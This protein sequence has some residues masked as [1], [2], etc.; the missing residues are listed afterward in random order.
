MAPKPLSSSSALSSSSS[1]S[2]S[3]GMRQHLLPSGC[4]KLPTEL[5]AKIFLTALF[6]LD[7]PLPQIASTE[8]LKQAPTVFT[9]VCRRW[10]AVALSTPRLW[11]RISVTLLGHARPPKM[12]H[13]RLTKTKM[14]KQKQKDAEKVLMPE[15]VQFAMFQTWLAR[16]KAAP[17]SCSVHN[18][19]GSREICMRYLEALCTHSSH[20]CAINIVGFPLDLFPPLQPDNMQLLEELTINSYS[21]SA[22]DIALTR[23]FARAPR[24]RRVFVRSADTATWRFPWAQLRELYL[25]D[26]DTKDGGPQFDASG[27]HRI[28]SSCSSNLTSL[29]LAFSCPTESPT[30]PLPL[31]VLAPIHLP[32]VLELTLNVNEFLPCDPLLR[33]L[34]L[35]SLRTLKLYT[36]VYP[37]AR[38]LATLRALF[39]PFADTL[40]A[41]DISECKLRAGDALALLRLVPALTA[42]NTCWSSCITPE[43]VR[44]LTLHWDTRGRLEGGQNAMLREL[45]IVKGLGNGG[46]RGHASDM[47][48]GEIEYGACLAEML[49]SRWRVPMA[50]LEVQTA[51]TSI[52]QVREREE[53]ERMEKADKAAER[54][55]CITLR[56]RDLTGMA[57]TKGAMRRWKEEGLVF[58]TVMY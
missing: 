5:L 36:S 12:R 52:E 46:G 27:Y 20:W 15:D 41:L 50:P 43:F 28:L 26:I 16:S 22:H 56:E 23:A 34:Q 53:M 55:R 57:K 4:T 17:L 14:S 45:K 21:S 10:R 25:V 48:E 35:T 54:L 8:T 19:H 13:R 51:V 31:T 49:E 33:Q 38:A 29:H 44:A 24:L 11:A 58:N 37:P 3:R 2:S 30:E 1:A 7:D 39:A 47:E 40:R 18:M 6:A 9:Q 32:N 42:L